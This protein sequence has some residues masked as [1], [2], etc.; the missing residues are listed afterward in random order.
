[1]PMLTRPATARCYHAAVATHLFVAP[2]AAAFGEVL[3]GLRLAWE[4]H[5]R[6]DTVEFLAPST[7]RV[8]LAGTPFRHGVSDAVL[9][10]LDRA[11]PDVARAR[12]P[13]TITLVDLGV[14]LVA[15]HAYRL[16]P[17]FLAALPAP[18]VALDVFDVGVGGGRVFDMGETA[19]TMPALPGVT[20][21]RLVPVPLAPPTAT[22]AYAACSGAAPPTPEERG[23]TRAAL[24]IGPDEPLV[25]FTTA[26]FQSRGLSPFQGRAVAAL[27]AVLA[28]LFE[29]IGARV[30]HLGPAPLGGLGPRYRHQGPVAP[31]EF[32]R[33]L[34]AADVLFTLN[35]AATS[36]VTAL[37]LDVPVV[38][39]VS[40]LA[41]GAAEAAAGLSAPPEP[42]VRAVLERV[43]P[44]CP[45][46]V[47]P[48]GLAAFMAPLLDGNPYRAA[49]TEVELFDAPAVIAAVRGLL[50][51]G[52]VRAA[53]LARAR[54][55]RAAA[56]ALPPAAARFYSDQ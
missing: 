25:V 54:A 31:T 10:V 56:A 50:G 9:R 20:L 16:D 48:L 12:R 14:T 22:G 17:G 44:L 28:V 52:P 2:G 55:Y 42:A 32:R 19:F 11:L 5:A 43:A 21:R 51:D 29:G 18:L 24:G 45:F 27:P 38:A 8:L 1:M 30:L 15:C 39:A 47:F 3:L 36:I 53:A 26:R 49:V 37:E 7:Y 46:R 41:G 34:A 35:L 33:L 40:S 6:G 4:L 23:A 13:A